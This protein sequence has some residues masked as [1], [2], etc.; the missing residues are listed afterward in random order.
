MRFQ[1][2][3]LSQG[4]GWRRAEVPEGRAP[5]D[6]RADNVGGGDI[7]DRE[8]ELGTTSVFFF[9]HIQNVQKL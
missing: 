3:V 4:R 8:P 5:H 2:H 7:A 1:R 6:S 9:F